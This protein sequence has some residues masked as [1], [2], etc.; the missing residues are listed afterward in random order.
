MALDAVYWTKFVVGMGYGVL[1]AWLAASNPT[2]LITYLLII[3]AALLY[4]IVAEVFWRLFD[5]K[6][7]RR[8]SYLNGL[9]GYAGMFLLV[10][11]LMYN[12]FAGA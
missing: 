2:P 8:Q 4:V 12:L 3:G 9:G 11:I 7:R 5:K 6:L 1:A 10:W